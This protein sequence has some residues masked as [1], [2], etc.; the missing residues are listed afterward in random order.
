MIQINIPMPKCCGDCFAL[1]DNG[2]YPRCLITE[3]QRGYTFRIREKRMPNC[4]LKNYDE[5]IK[6]IKT[7]E[8]RITTA[9][10]LGLFIPAYW[11]GECRF[12]LIEHP[13]Y[14]S[15]CGKRITGGRRCQM[16]IT[17]S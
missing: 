16:T 3:E 11:C 4:P 7:T 5:E 14:C 8:E 9:K 12:M 17:S 1:D 6:P 15:N 2:D 13:K 10:E